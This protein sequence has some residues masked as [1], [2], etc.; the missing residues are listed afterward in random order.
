MVYKANREISVHPQ[1]FGLIELLSD[2]PSTGSFSLL[3]IDWDGFI[4]LA[5]GK[6]AWRWFQ[7]PNTRLSSLSSSRPVPED[8]LSNLNGSLAA[9]SRRESRSANSQ[10]SALFISVF[11]RSSSILREVCP[12][13]I[14]GTQKQGELQRTAVSKCFHQ[15]PDDSS[16]MTDDNVLARIRSWAFP[17]TVIRPQILIEAEFL[18][19][20]A[21]EIQAHHCF[22][23][24]SKGCNKLRWAQSQQMILDTNINVNRFLM[25]KC[26]K[27]Y[28]C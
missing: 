1:A 10:S 18:L 23:A 25:S 11:W 20:D 4:D 9:E 15:S 24:G 8:P 17:R 13:I 21:S 12:L 6:L 22:L 19:R 5:H 26:A 27:C 14:H 2:R 7:S 28:P 3:L 16:L